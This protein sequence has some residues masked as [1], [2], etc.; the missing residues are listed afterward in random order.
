MTKRFIAALL[1]IL[2][3]LTGTAL[4]EEFQAVTPCVV[5]STLKEASK[6]AGFSI[7]APEKVDG[8]TVT[9]HAWKDEL[10]EV[11]YDNGKN[12]LIVRKGKGESDVSGDR[13]VYAKKVAYRFSGITATLKGNGETPTLITWSYKGYSYSL[14]CSICMDKD[15]AL[16]AMRRLSGIRETKKQR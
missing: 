15:Y 14:S 5:C 6:V 9:I 16:N 3:I 1:C 8:C 11:R 13:T 10:I 4:A 7:A 12:T 2:T